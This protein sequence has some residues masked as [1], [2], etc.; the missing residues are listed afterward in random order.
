MATTL[1]LSL[2]SCT[3]QMS[4][5]PATAEEPLEVVV[6]R[7]KA[8]RPQW[9]T[10]SPGQLFA[11]GGEIRMLTTRSRLSN[12]I[13]GLNQT[14]IAA[15]DATKLAVATRIQA[16]LI[17]FTPNS[18]PLLKQRWQRMVLESTAK[19]AT[20][21]IKV[22]DIYYEGITRQVAN[23]QDPIRQ[24]YLVAVLVSLPKET[25]TGIYNDLARRL[26]NEPESDWQALVARLKQVL[27][28]GTK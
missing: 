22:S 11:A 19:V 9:M 27:A 10:A 20:S 21:V 7:S 12:L 5:Q 4:N 15:L 23:A 26:V 6:E 17:D 3:Q 8:V 16:Q 13:L 2:T 18:T 14:E 25:I 24:Y 28:L 1:V